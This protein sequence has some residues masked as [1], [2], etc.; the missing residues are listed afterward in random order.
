VKQRSV[1]AI[2]L[3]H[4]G[5]VVSVDRLIDELWG[6]N[7]PKDAP[8]SVHQHVSRLRKLLE[9]HTVVVTRQP[10]YV[11]ER[12]DGRLDLDR[13][14]ELRD[15]GRALLKGG[16]ASQAAQTLRDALELWRGRPLA[17][18]ENEPF[19]RDAIAQ[20]DEAWLDALVVRVDADLAL[21]RH[22]E[23]IGELQTLVRRRPLQERLRAQLMLALYRSGRQSEALR[24]YADLRRTLVEELGLEPGLELQ[25][26]QSAILN[27]DPGIAGPPS[28]MRRVASSRGAALLAVGA[29]VVAAAVVVAFAVSRGGTKS[30]GA[31]A[32]GPGLLVAID[33]S[34]AIKRRIP[35]GRTPSA[36]AEGNGALWVVDADARTVLRVDESSG[37]V[38]TL[39]TGATPADVAVGDGAV[40]V[41]NARPLAGAQFVG[42][43][44]T[45]VAQLDAAT[46]TIRAQT[47]LPHR[48][49]DVSNLTENRITTT[50]GALWAVTPDYAVVRIDSSTGAITGSTRAVHAVAIAAGGAGVWALGDDGTVAKLDR[51]T[52][53]PLARTHID[54]PVAAIGVGND[55]VWVTSEDGTLWRVPVDR[56]SSLGSTTLARGTADVAVG[57]NAVWVANPLAA[58][59]TQVDPTTARVVRTIELGGSP[60]SLV[61]D[62]DTVWAAVVADPTASS[63]E[64][65]GVHTLPASTCEPVI[66]GGKRA[67]VLVV[68]DLP[69]QGGNRAQTTQMTRAIA[70]VLRERG[71]RAG[72]FRIAYQSCDDSLARTGIYDEAKCAANARAYAKNGN[73]V[74]VIGT[75]N[76]PCAVA[77]VPELNRASPGPLAMVSP[78]N[79][80]VGLTRAGPG[81]DPALPAALYPSARRNYVRVYPTDD[82]QGAALA[83]LIHDR[84]HH[85]VFVLD[86]GNWGYGAPMAEGFETAAKRLGLEVVGRA[87]W[88]PGDAS[89][90]TLARRVAR[91]RPDAVFIGGLLDTNAAAV[92]RDVRARLGS[93]VDLV[94]PDGLTPLPLLVARSGR[95]AL[96]M[97][98]S[99][100]GVVT[101]RLPPSGRRFVRAFARTQAGVQIEPSAVYAAQATEVLLDAISH[102]DGTRGSIVDELF[103]T[104]VRN[105]LLGSFGFNADGDVTESP[106]TI[107][108]VRRGGSSTTVQSVEG[109]VVER[110]VRPSAKLV[111]PAG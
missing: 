38:D 51:R 11:I 107:I 30:S 72:R 53:Q 40:W 41:G 76:S 49:G 108:R 64:T 75:Y 10:G 39:A 50:S 100:P 48:P 18:L 52:A 73:V 62:G 14:E 43:V 17:D 3:L 34:G 87:S 19:A 71:F 28:G 54:A 61:V 65:H 6:D 25:H 78:S 5:E 27:Q 96:G 47:P 98:V 57:R 69:L 8:T 44:M 59:L 15:R 92:V 101:E 82:L 94:G 23:L 22:N 12:R 16:D 79:S 13:F 74:G 91:S 1:L 89:Y 55:A 46:R 110:V 83:L 35:A 104:H 56:L 24:E 106:I 36:I 90:A 31:V 70:F 103:D 21:G 111:A 4:R 26:L 32:Q 7:P 84:G 66:A 58:T 37:S 45:S 42:P 109:G 97:D 105:G 67:D 95:A 80:F 99:L 86:D 9:P 2:L 81:V 29:V 102:S 63:K 33:G 68:S 88:D 85:R 77:A 60:R 20:L 93:G